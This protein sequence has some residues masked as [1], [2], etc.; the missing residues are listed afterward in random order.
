MKECIVKLLLCIVIALTFGC[1]ENKSS[2]KDVSKK[3]VAVSDEKQE[4]ESEKEV[5]DKKQEDTSKEGLNFGNDPKNLVDKDT[6]KRISEVIQEG[7]NE[8]IK[9]YDSYSKR[10][11][12]IEGKLTVRISLFTDGKKDI[13]LSG[14]LPENFKT[15]VMKKIETWSFPKPKSKVVLMFSLTF[16]ND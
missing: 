5:S 16:T 4:S 13:E 7:K 14:E 6:K 12:K 11:D 1:S 3:V 2:A 10:G 9:I 15:E 8:I